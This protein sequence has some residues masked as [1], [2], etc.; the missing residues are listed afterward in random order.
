[1]TT[2]PCMSKLGASPMAMRPIMEMHDG[3][4]KMCQLATYHGPVYL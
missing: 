1:M 2:E 4:S 3:L